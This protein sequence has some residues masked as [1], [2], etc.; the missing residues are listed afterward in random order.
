M[1]SKN[2]NKEGRGIN[3]LLSSK[4]DG[5]TEDDSWLCFM[6]RGSAGC[7]VEYKYDVDL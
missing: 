4:E 3:I 5:H 2:E 6:G 7:R 1:V